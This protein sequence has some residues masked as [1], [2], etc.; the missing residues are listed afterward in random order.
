MVGSSCGD[1]LLQI[2]ASFPDLKAPVVAGLA[3]ALHGKEFEKGP[4]GALRGPARDRDPPP[5]EGAEGS[6]LPAPAPAP[7]SPPVAARAAGA[8]YALASQSTSSAAKKDL[9]PAVAPLAGLLEAA[10]ALPAPAEPFGGKAG[11]AALCALLR[12]VSH[13]PA[14]AILHGAGAV[15]IVERLLLQARHLQASAPELLAP[16]PELE[17]GASAAGTSGASQL[18]QLA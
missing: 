18:S 1:A 15:A 8:L 17:A 12:L 7:P 9:L 2:A 4:Q 6:S 16:P 14:R 5:S 3:A 10:A 11:G 13:P